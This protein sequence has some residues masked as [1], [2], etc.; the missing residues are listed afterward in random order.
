M[1]TTPGRAVDR[2][3]VTVSVGQWVRVVT[4]SGDWFDK[5]P[6][7]ERAE[8]ESMIGEIFLVEEIDEY[9]HP[10]VEK[11]WPDESD[12]TCRSHSVAL[13]SDEM[14]LVAGPVDPSEPP[15]PSD[16]ART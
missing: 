4:L 3:G 11:S 5:L 12:G 10:W 6:A 14:E 8:V 7:N 2:H 13:E 1:K 16:Q 15:A 9:G